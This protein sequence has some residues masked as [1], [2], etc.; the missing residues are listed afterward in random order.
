MDALANFFPEELASAV[1]GFDD[2]T[3]QAILAVLI[4]QGDSAFM[5]IANELNISKPLLS[6]HLDLLL[7]SS[8]VR[9]YSPSELKGRFDSYYGISAFGKDFVDALFQPFSLKAYTIPSYNP[10]P[11]SSVTSRYTGGTST[12]IAQVNLPLVVAGQVTSSKGLA[13]P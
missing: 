11:N 2:K 3:R 4:H 8:L 12:P 9:N 1:K 10:S 7:D 13:S 5:E 6:H